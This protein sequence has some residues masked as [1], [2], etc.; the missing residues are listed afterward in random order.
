MR[1]TVRLLIIAPRL[2]STL[3]LLSHSFN[4]PS[5]IINGFLNPMALLNAHPNTN[6][7]LQTSTPIDQQVLNSPAPS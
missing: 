2:L 5:D 3:K 4:L 6:Q 1:N 7:S